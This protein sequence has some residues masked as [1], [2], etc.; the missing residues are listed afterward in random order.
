MNRNEVASNYM[1]EVVVHYLAG[2]MP[3][4]LLAAYEALE[5][6][7]DWP[8]RGHVLHAIA[9]VS[10]AVGERMT[11]RKWWSRLLEN[12]KGQN[13]PPE[14]LAR[15]YFDAAYTSRVSGDRGTAIS[16]YL[17]ALELFREVDTQHVSRTLQNLA[18]TYTLEGDVE[19][20]SAYLQESHPISLEGDDL[21]HQLVGE[22]FLM[23]VSGNREQASAV[24][25]TLLN[26]QTTSLVKAQAC[27]AFGATTDDKDVATM[28]LDRM[29]GFAGDD[30]NLAGDIHHLQKHI[31]T[32]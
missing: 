14:K 12:A 5:E 4:A 3:R 17:K 24:A 31:D 15:S 20:A 11:A 6:G 19:Q 25:E 7:A 10:S 30:A 32:L 8:V 1:D 28:W 23:A 13:F 21:Y 22:A 16:Y 26:A 18:W 9:T 27:Y 29:K 2:D